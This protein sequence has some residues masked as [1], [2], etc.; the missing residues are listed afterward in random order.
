MYRDLRKNFQG[1]GMKSDM[2]Q[3]VSKCEICQQVKAKHQRPV[4]TLQP[5]PVADWKWDHVMMDFITGLPRTQ[6]GHDTIW[7]IIE[8]L[9][10][11]T[12]FLLVKK[13]DTILMLAKVYVKKV[14]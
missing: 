6:C 2:A 8:R 13:T 12:H 10:K 14:L 5:L 1:K 9:T 7:V 11:T 3:C 4:E